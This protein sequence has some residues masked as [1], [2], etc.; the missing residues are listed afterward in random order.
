MHV[1]GIHIFIRKLN[2]VKNPNGE[3]NAPYMG[4]VLEVVP[5][6]MV[7]VL[8]MLHI[9]DFFYYKLVG[10]PAHCSLHLVGDLLNLPPVFHARAL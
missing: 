6:Q 2:L 7:Y 4:D 1:Y 3:K 10:S 8:A 5:F 9:L